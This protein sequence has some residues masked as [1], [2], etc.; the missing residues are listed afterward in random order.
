MK[1]ITEKKQSLH[2]HCQDRLNSKPIYY[3]TSGISNDCESIRKG[4]Y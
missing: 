2:I 1:I 3:E 4:G